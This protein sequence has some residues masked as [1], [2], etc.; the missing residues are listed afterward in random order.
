MLVNLYSSI[1]I[2]FSRRA[3]RLPALQRDLLGLRPRTPRFGQ[4]PAEVIRQAPHRP[5]SVHSSSSTH[6]QTAVSEMTQPTSYSSLSVFVNDSLIA[7]QPRG[8]HS[9]RQVQTLSINLDTGKIQIQAAEPQLGTP[10]EVLAVLGLCKL[11]A[12]NALVVVTSAHPAAHLAGSDIFEVAGAKVVASAAARS[13]RAN[14]GLLRLLEDAVDPQGSGR[15][16]HFSYTYDLTQTTQRIA[17]ALAAD[18]AGWAGKA[19]VQRA[20][21]RFFWNKAIAAPL[22][23]AG[24]SA[25]VQPCILGFVEQLPNLEFNEPQTGKKVTGTLTLLARRS[26]ARAGTRQWRRGA[27]ASGSVANFAETEQILTIDGP[28]GHP[29]TGSVSSYVVVRGSIPLLWTQLP[30]IKYKPTTVIAPS[31]QSGP[32]HDKHFAS[33]VDD[34]ESVVAINLVNHHGTEGKLEA[35]FRAESTRLISS[36]SPV[37]QRTRY[38]AFDFHAECGNKRYH[39]L[40][41]LWDQVSKDVAS[42]GFCLLSDALKGP[43]KTQ[44]GV[45]RINCID[46]LDRTNVVQGVLARKALEAVLIS[47]NLLGKSATLPEAYPE[48][49]R[50]FKILWADHGD[51]LSTQYAGTGAMKSGFTRTGKRTIGGVID[52]GVK[53]VVRYYLNNYQDG[54]KQDAIDLMTGT[55]QCDTIN[56][57]PIKPQPSPM[58]PFL[59]SLLALGLAAH[60]FSAVMGHVIGGA[61]APTITADAT[62]DAGMLGSARKLASSV[63]FTPPPISDPLPATGEIGRAAA[64]AAAGSA[65]V[66]PFLAGAMACYVIAPL[67]LGV[68]LLFLLIRNGKHLVNKPQLCPQLAVTVAKPAKESKKAA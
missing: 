64:S 58:V 63:I 20:S 54:F 51:M 26:V 25:F 52:D 53:A 38:V 17:T 8:P 39:R 10:M 43:G 1:A 7:I 32:A 67:V 41:V 40:S 61:T 2:P 48:V 49:E 47:F 3:Y 68:G 22:V 13:N 18:P 65:D 66:V 59:I 16:L 15:G 24:A 23:S 19:P 34:Y 57:P 30:N 44:S 4:V 50:Q 14:K 27:D 29:L 9:S 45:M 11:H 12:G 31:E 42:Q 37:G 33:L 21:G 56:A 5:N 35:A 60:N 46:C 36:Q 55:Y 28:Q 62:M 6:T